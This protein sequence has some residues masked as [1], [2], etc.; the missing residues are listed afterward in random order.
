MHW[1]VL[2]RKGRLRR[3]RFNTTLGEH[4]ELD[5]AM[6]R[7]AIELARQAASLG[8]VPVGAVVYG[9]PGTPDEGRVF[10]EAFNRREFDQDP[11]AHAEF[12]AIVSA[13]RTLRSWRLTNCTVAVTLEPC[14]MCAGLIV[15]ARVGRV[16]YGT[17]DSKAGAVC[18]LYSLLN[19]PR[20]NHRP[21]V[22]AGVLGHECSAILT[23]FFR[24]L[25]TGHGRRPKQRHA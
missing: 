24:S 6:M 15:N 20:L 19:D 13:S 14:V 25:R 10:G 22:E 4:V 7:R 23:D 3:R 8:E 9:S 11:A 18:S 2:A 16:V 21:A 5:L 17:D 12:A 1:L